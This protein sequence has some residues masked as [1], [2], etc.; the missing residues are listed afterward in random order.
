MEAGIELDLD[1]RNQLFGESGPLT[2]LAAKARLGHALGL[3]GRVTRDDIILISKIRNAFAHSPQSLG[4][5]DGLNYDQT[6]DKT[7]DG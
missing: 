6:A 3:Y 2:S 4:R 7:D 5:V 1:E